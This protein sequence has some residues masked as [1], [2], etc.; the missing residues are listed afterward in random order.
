MHGIAG[1]L[2]INHSDVLHGD[3]VIIF[4]PDKGCN[5]T[6]EGSKDQ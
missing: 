6:D 5:N 1:V 2:G 3:K 4:W